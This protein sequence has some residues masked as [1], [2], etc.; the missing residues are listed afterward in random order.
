MAERKLRRL[1]YKN[2]I[3]ML[4]ALPQVE[5]F[6]H[7]YVVDESGNEFD[8]VDDGDLSCAVV[9]S[10]ILCLF[11]WI[12]RPH[13]TVASTIKALVENG[14]RAT[15][16]PKSGDIV[17]YSASEAGHEHVGFFMGN[18]IVISNI[19]KLRTPGKHELMMSD[20]RLP[21]GYYTRNYEEDLNGQEEENE[22]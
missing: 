14:W 17:H 2:Y 3:S 22:S 15:E 4:N 9:V 7:L 10:S 11:G 19:A 21:I 8:A 16:T 1:Q 6:R 18:D 20:G 13:A 12:D 5:L